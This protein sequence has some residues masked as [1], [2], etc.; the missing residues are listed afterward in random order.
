ML[1]GQHVIPSYPQHVIPSYPVTI[2]KTIIINAP[3]WARYG[4]SAVS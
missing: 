4:L 3:P 1:C 2:L